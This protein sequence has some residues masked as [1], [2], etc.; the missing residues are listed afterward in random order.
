M[1]EEN[2]ARRET[3]AVIRV[4]N[5]DDGEMVLRWMEKKVNS[6]KIDPTNPNPHCLA[7]KAYQSELVEQIKRLRKRKDLIKE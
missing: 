2:E 7:M 5:T 4:F 6:I 3:V 1:S